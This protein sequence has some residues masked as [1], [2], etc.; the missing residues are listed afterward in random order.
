MV[1]GRFTKNVEN[2]ICEHCGLSVRG[3][4]YTNHCPKC[5]WSKHVDVF[6][7]DRAEPCKGLMKPVSIELKNGGYSIIHK[8]VICGKV[9]K[10]KKA[11]SDNFNALVSIAEGK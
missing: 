7:G 4:G 2:F 10:N 1:S 11:T 3:N 5:L 8:C 6:P 9:R